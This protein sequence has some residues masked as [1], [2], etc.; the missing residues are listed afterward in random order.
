LPLRSKQSL[1]DVRQREDGRAE[2]EGVA[3]LLEHVELAA[4]L[5]VLLEY[6]DVVTRLF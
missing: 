3:L 6:L 5:G 4:D 1:E 2:V